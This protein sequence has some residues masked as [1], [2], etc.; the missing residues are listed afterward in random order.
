LRKCNIGEVLC[1]YKPQNFSLK[2]GIFSQREKDFYPIYSVGDEI[3]SY[4]FLQSQDLSYI[5]I[6]ITNIM[7]KRTLKDIVHWAM[8]PEG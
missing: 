7:T 4:S 8:A 2:E 3:L 5:P 6:S 1:I